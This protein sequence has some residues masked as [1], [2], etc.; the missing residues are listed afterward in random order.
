MTKAELNDI[1]RHLKGALKAVERSIV[2]I[3][4][5]EE[6]KKLDKDMK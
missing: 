3:E 5:T 6:E 1:R 2:R 4:I